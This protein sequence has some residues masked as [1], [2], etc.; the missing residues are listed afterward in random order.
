VI[1]NFTEDDRVWNNVEFF[2]LRQHPAAHMSRYIS[3]EFSCTVFGCIVK[4]AWLSNPDRGVDA[5]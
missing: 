2:A 4:D 1:P 5:D 3:I